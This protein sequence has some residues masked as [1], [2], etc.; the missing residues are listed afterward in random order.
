MECVKIKSLVHHK[1]YRVHIN[2]LKNF[3]DNS[4][5]NPFPTVEAEEENEV[6]QDLDNSDEEE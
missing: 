6:D 3:H 4:N 1:L 5:T 2:N